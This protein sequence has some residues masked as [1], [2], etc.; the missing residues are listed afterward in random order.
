VSFRCTMQRTWDAGPSLSLLLSSRKSA[1][2]SD[3]SSYHDILPSPEAQRM[4]PLNLE[5]ELPQPLA[6]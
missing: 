3:S 5:L 2:C 6:K 4:G 1:V